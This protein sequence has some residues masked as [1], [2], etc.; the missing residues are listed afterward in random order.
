L[1]WL[2]GDLNFF[3][4]KLLD[5]VGWTDQDGKHRANTQENISEIAEWVFGEGRHAG[6]SVIET[7]TKEDRGILG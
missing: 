7:L 6:R 1:H 4:I 3:L 5:T 2:R